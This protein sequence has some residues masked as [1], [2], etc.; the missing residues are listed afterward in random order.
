MITMGSVFAVLTVLGAGTAWFI[1]HTLDERQKPT[2][3]TA[4]REDAKADKVE[5]RGGEAD[6]RISAARADRRTDRVSA[7]ACLYAEPVDLTMTTSTPAAQIYYTTTGA[8]PTEHS[9]VY[10]GPIRVPPGAMVRARLRG[11]A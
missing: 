6:A 9:S 5:C 10:V 8:E 7:V 4:K 2:S 3:T 1:K 11:P